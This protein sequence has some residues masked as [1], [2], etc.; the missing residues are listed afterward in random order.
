[1][2]RHTHWH[3][4]TKSTLDGH[5]PK[6]RWCREMQEADLKIKVDIPCMI[7]KENAYFLDSDLMWNRAIWFSCFL[8]FFL[9][10]VAFFFF[11]LP[12]PCSFQSVPWSPEQGVRRWGGRCPG[13]RQQGVSLIEDAPSTPGSLISV[14]AEQCIRY[15]S[16][17]IPTYKCFMQQNVSP[18]SHRLCLQPGGLPG[19]CWVTAVNSGSTWESWNREEGRVFIRY[20]PMGT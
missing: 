10:G 8:G 18:A 7:R 16:L 19:L 17:N 1:M 6:F 15:P 14:S 13:E 5:R 12:P 11:F 2:K 4:E 3:I 9:G 20:L